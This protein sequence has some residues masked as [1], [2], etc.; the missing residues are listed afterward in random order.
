MKRSLAPVSTLAL[1]SL[2]ASLPVLADDAQRCTALS[3]NDP[4][5]SLSLH[6]WVAAGQLPQANPGRAALTGAALS[7]AAMPAHCLVQGVIGARTGADGQ[8][9][10]SHFELRLP[11]PWNGRFLFQ[12]GGG[13]DGVVGQALGAIP[14]RGASALP[15]LD[16]G[17]AVVVTDSGHTGKD[18]SDAR[19]GLD[20]QARLDYA[21]AAIGSVTTQAKALILAYYG[22]APRHSVFMGCSNGGRSA[23]MAAQRYPT[24]FD[25]IIAG[26]PGLRL[27]R[28]AVAQA[29]DTQAF[30]RVAPR[31]AEGQPILAQALTQ[32]DQDLIAKAVLARCDG[33][34]G[35]KDG[36]IDAM[37]H[38]RFDPSVLACAAG[39]ASGCLSQAKVDALHAVF[40]GAHDS[41]GQ[42][43]YSD[44]P[45]DAGIA[46]D[47][48]RVW[49]LGTSATAKANARNATLTPG[50][51]GYYFMT[52]AQPH[53]DM[54]QFNFDQAVETTAQ[55]GAINDAVATQYSTFTRGGG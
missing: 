6:Q 32:A 15:A 25:G 55:T 40:N 8:A 45:W 31:T 21:Y 18:N 43:L 22:K 11:S 48:W 26:N 46:S 20:Q 23:L 13:M 17:Y 53:L 27:S 33:L 5:V 14:F 29:W 24:Q 3:S 38:C 10:G 16:R 50:S 34:D 41:H 52:P 36:S 4:A 39:Q 42:A 51:L 44:W 49:K 35:L 30:S 9:Y 1:L 37:S 54:S 2:C 7:K 19:F 47:G 12:G 28:A